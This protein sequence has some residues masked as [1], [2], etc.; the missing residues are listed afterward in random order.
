MSRTT[1]PRPPRMMNSTQLTLK[2]ANMERSGA[3]SFLILCLAFF[4]SLAAPCHQVEDQQWNTDHRPA[5][6]Q[7]KV[8]RLEVVPEVPHEKHLGRGA[9]LAL[10][11]SH[12]HGRPRQGHKARTPPGFLQG[13]FD[14]NPAMTYSRPRRTTIGP[15][16]LTAV[17]GMGTGVT[18][19][20]C[21]PRRR[22]CI[23]MAAVE[24]CNSAM[25]MP[26]G[27]LGGPR[28]G[29]MRQSVRLLVPVS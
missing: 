28:T 20:V 24:N 10:V 6:D 27:A 7:D 1:R 3:G 13:A 5:G 11:H 23:K 14:K 15:G 16:C 22:T 19:R 26:R 29:S 4:L 8:E 17:F 9:A 25:R 2:M 18:I 21:S 12:T